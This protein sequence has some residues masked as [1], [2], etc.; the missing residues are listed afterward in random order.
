MLKSKVLIAI[1]AIWA[2]TGAF[3][4]TTLG[5]QTLEGLMSGFGEEH[6]LVRTI[7]NLTAG[8]EGCEAGTSLMVLLNTHMEYKTNQA[9]LMLALQGNYEVSIYVDGCVEGNKLEIKS[10][11]VQG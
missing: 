9:L 1:L 11:R 2:S 10:V 8:G 7:E 5:F 3:A 6:M 4:G